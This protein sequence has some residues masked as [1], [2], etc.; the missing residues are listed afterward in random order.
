MATEYNM[1]TTGTLS[2][3]VI[4]DLGGVS[5]THPTTVDLTQYVPEEEVIQSISY[6]DLKDLIAAGHV[7][8]ADEGGHTI[9]SATPMG[10]QEASNVPVTPVGNLT[11]TNVQAALQE[12]Q[13]E[14]DNLSLSGAAVAICKN[15]TL[16]A[17][18]PHVK[19]NFVGVDVVD[20]GGGQADVRSGRR[21]DFPVAAQ[22]WAIP[23]NRG[24]EP[25]HKIY[26]GGVERKFANSY[27]VDTNNLEVDWGPGNLKTGYVIIT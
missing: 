19:L 6:G 4:D 12:L 18:T 16:I 22:V 15:G 17:N 9:D 2:P 5:F 26:S 8:I 10:P 13:T 1:T 25:D 14:L 24:V 11:S 7:N 21:F 27:H 20:A 3:V 23:H